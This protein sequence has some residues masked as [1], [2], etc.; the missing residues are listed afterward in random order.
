M[1]NVFRALAMYAMCLSIPAGAVTL[2]PN[3]GIAAAEVQLHRDHDDHRDADI[4]RGLARRAA[5]SQSSEA[6]RYRAQRRAEIRHD[7][8][9]DRHGI[10]RHDRRCSTV[11]RD[12]RRFRV[13]RD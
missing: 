13:C 10:N 9:H 12:G 5:T 11:H 4:R 6:R 3:D 8:R 2:L 1:K 7:R